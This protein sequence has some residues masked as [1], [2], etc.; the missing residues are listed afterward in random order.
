[1]PPCARERGDDLPGDGTA[2]EGRLPARRDSRQGPGEV[3][4]AEPLAHRVGPSGVEEHPPRRRIGQ[5]L[6][7]VLAEQLDILRLEHEPVPREGDGRRQ[8]S[9]PRHRAIPPPRV[10]QPR[11]RARGSDAQVAVQALLRVRLAV[12]VQVH[13]RRGGQRRALAEVDEGVYA[14][15][16]PRGRR[17]DHHEPAAAD[18]AAAGMDH[19]QGVADRH[20]RIDGIPAPAQHRGADIRR[21][22][23]GGDHHA[24]LG[25]RDLPHGLSG[26][27]TPEEG[28]QE[29]GRRRQRRF[30]RR[31]IPNHSV[32][33]VGF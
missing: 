33:F 8:Q 18:V 2:I 32:P 12:G 4:L 27:G 6:G 14:G 20:R 26:G 23:L 1:M 11:D 10:F 16:A 9:G 30:P 3:R 5:E 25:P 13:V 15:F 7:G 24:G 19:G 31:R 17:V 28:E 22:V 21:V 29:S